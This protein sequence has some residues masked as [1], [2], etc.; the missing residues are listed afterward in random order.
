[1][2]H[3]SNS[4]DSV[5]VDFWKISNAHGLHL[6]WGYTEAVKWIGEWGKDSDIFREFAIAL[7]AHLRRNHMGE[8]RMRGLL[9]TCLE[10]YHEHAHPISLEVDDAI[11]MAR[12]AKALRTSEAG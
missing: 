11:R 2:S 1:M 8:Y 9:A 6:K 7:E 4:A 5:R 10:P 12:S 3:Y